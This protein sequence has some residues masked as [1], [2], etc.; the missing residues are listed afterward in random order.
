[1]F[2][3]PYISFFHLPVNGLWVTNF[4]TFFDDPLP[5][6]HW[7]AVSVGGEQFKIAFASAPSAKEP[8]KDLILV[9]GVQ[10]KTMI[11]AH[12]SGNDALSVA[13]N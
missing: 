3:H 8:A 5:S 12:S 2:N 1:M 11:K 6:L 4:R 10:L 13:R 7:C 9:H